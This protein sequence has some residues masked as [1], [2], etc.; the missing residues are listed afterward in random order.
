[1]KTQGFSVGLCKIKEVGQYDY[2]SH[3]SGDAYY[4]Y[5]DSDNNKDAQFR[6]TRKEA[7]KLI[8]LLTKKLKRK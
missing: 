6:L 4:I 8:N 1:M 3:P 7:R 5:V 2:A